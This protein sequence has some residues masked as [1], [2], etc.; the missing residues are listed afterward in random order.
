LRL[1]GET[2]H[3]RIF[4]LLLAS[5]GDW[6]LQTGRPAEAALPLL[7]AHN[8]P[9][10]DHETRARARE[11]LADATAVLTSE[12]YDVAVE[13]SRDVGPA[14]LAE[15]LISLLTVPLPA[16]FVPVSPPSAPQHPG[17]TSALVEQLTVREMSVLRLIAAGHSD[18]QIA[19]ELFLA[20]NTIRSYNQRLYG[21]L[22]V[23]SRT[24][25]VARARDLGL[26]N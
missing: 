13:R 12:A 18:L 24:Q 15:D 25:A 1:A 6:L 5:A 10:S 22:G 2:R 19:D 9:A 26:L 17:A 14:E 8:H 11:L 20:V 3:T 4:I 21:K 16:G 23:S 7:F